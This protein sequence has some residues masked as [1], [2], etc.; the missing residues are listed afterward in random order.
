MSEL[1]KHVEV[2]SAEA[3]G[4]ARGGAKG[5]SAP[6]LLMESLH[7]LSLVVQTNIPFK[8]GRLS[9]SRL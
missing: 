3:S 8:N 4:V 9:A 2:C 6:P 1:A 5:A 7:I